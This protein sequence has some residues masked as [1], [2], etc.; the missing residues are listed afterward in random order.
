MHAV[1][2]CMRRFQ[3][4]ISQLGSRGVFASAHS[5]WVSS[6][7][8]ST[9]SCDNIFLPMTA[10]GSRSASATTTNSVGA[11]CK[12]PCDQLINGIFTAA[13]TELSLNVPETSKEQEVWILLTRHVQDTSQKG[14]FV[15]LQAHIQDAAAMVP[16]DPKHLASQVCS[17]AHGDGAVLIILNVGNVH[18]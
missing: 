14:E 15:S 2:R 8:T 12:N 16:S 17:T 6:A 13:R 11:H 18:E 5:A 3:W 1:R 4:D 7:H 9:D 10:R